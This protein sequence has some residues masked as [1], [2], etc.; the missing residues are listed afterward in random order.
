MNR[1]PMPGSGPP[2]FANGWQQSQGL[3]R[4]PSV[5]D[6]D[7]SVKA[8]NN[9][10]KPTPIHQKTDKAP[11]PQPAKNTDIQAD[12]DSGDK[13]APSPEVQPVK[14]APVRPPDDS[15]GRKSKKAAEVMDNEKENQNSKNVQD[16]QASGKVA[17]PTPRKEPEEQ[18]DDYNEDGGKVDGL[19]ED[20]TVQ[21]DENTNRER[22]L[23]SSP[24]QKNINDMVKERQDEEDEENDVVPD[25]GLNKSHKEIQEQGY[26]QNFFEC[27]YEY[28]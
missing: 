16:S 17:D 7:I 15:V 8:K 4:K 18:D 11:Q 5:K 14:A 1:P 26:L 27:P 22:G 25:V 10:N 28:Q 20:G 21:Q 6:Q 24:A 13:K 23:S 19:D 12:K 9:S 2:Q 3:P